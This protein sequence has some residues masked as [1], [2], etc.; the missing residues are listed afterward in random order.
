M[1]KTCNTPKAPHMYY[2]CDTTGHVVDSDNGTDNDVWNIWDTGG[3]VDQDQQVNM[4]RL[5]R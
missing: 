2:R 5:L 4:N 3:L 1:F